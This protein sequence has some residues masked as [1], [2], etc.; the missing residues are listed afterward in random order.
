M[1]ITSATSSI[2]S[3]KSVQSIQ[4]K[5]VIESTK[6]TKSVTTSSL[7]SHQS[8]EG[9]FGML[10][11]NFEVEGGGNF[12]KV[13]E[14]E[15]NNE[16]RDE[17]EIVVHAG[18]NNFEVTTENLAKVQNSEVKVRKI[19]LVIDMEKLCGVGIFAK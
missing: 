9:V 6:S 16:E 8:M 15:E 12:E 19:L 7:K 14:K 11:G 18:K 1:N 2:T 3:S 10:W 17:G 13:R 5:Q 4:T